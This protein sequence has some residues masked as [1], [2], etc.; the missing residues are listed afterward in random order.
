M[1]PTSTCKPNFVKSKM[2]QWQNCLHRTT[3]SWSKRLHLPLHNSVFSN[4]HNGVEK[5]LGSCC[6]SN[7]RHEGKMWKGAKKSLNSISAQAV[8]IWTRI[9]SGYKQHYH[10]CFTQRMGLFKFIGLGG[11]FLDCFLVQTPLANAR[12]LNCES[13]TD[14]RK[15]II[16]LDPGGLVCNRTRFAQFIPG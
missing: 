1:R 14:D 3:N 13:Y 11:V 2:C 8:N 16:S 5:V 10:L 9:S 4:N 7:I 12:S 15:W 6:F